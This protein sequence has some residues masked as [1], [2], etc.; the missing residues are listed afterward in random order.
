MSRRSPQARHWLSSSG[1]IF[2][3]VP[4]KNKAKESAN[5]Q[6]PG[7][8]ATCFTRKQGCQLLQPP[9]GAAWQ[10]LAFCPVA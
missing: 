3:A 1:L 8:S 5:W 9:E 2:S 4:E 6:G 7:A 10:G